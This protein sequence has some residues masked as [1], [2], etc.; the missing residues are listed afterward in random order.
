MDGDAKQAPQPLATSGAPIDSLAAKRACADLQAPAE[1]PGA[2]HSKGSLLL[3]KQLADSVDAKT[4]H[5]GIAVGL[6]CVLRQGACLDLA[7]AVD[8]TRNT[9]VGRPT[10]KACHVTAGRWSRNM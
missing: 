9:E 8:S 3:Q 10:A 6:A 1:S 5:D 7:E 2:V 4:G